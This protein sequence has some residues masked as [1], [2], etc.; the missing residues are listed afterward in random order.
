MKVVLIL[1]LILSLYSCDNNRKRAARIIDQNNP[2]GII[3]DT[4]EV[5]TPT[6]DQ[7]TN[8]QSA[9]A[10]DPKLTQA[11]NQMEFLQKNV[12]DSLADLSSSKKLLETNPSDKM[13]IDAASKDWNFFSSEANK[14]SQNYCQNIIKIDSQSQLQAG[15]LVN[16]QFVNQEKVNEICDLTQTYFQANMI[17]SEIAELTV[18]VIDDPA[19]VTTTTTTL[20]QTNDDTEITETDDVNEDEGSLPKIRYCSKEFLKAHSYTTT[21]SELFA[22]SIEDL[23]IQQA[24]ALNE[25]LSAAER[26][27]AKI[28]FEAKWKSSFGEK[29]VVDPEVPEGLF[30]DI[31]NAC[32]SLDRMVQEQEA[33]ILSAENKK[34]IKDSSSFQDIC[35]VERSEML[36]LNNAAQ[37]IANLKIEAEVTE[38]DPVVVVTE[39][40]KK[41]DKKEVVVEDPKK[42]KK[43]E[44]KKEEKEVV[45]QD[46]KKNKK[47]EVKKEEKEVVVQ[48]PKKDKKP[49]V[50]KEEKEVV[51]TEVK[52]DNTC[53]QPE[54]AWLAKMHRTAWTL[55]DNYKE[56]KSTYD[57]SKK[58]QDPKP[59]FKTFKEVYDS[60]IKG[61]AKDAGRICLT[62]EKYRQCEG[63]FPIMR[64]GSQRMYSAPS[65]EEVQKTC[66]LLKTHHM[67]IKTMVKN[68]NKRVKKLNREIKARNE[69]IKKKVSQ[70]DPCSDEIYDLVTEIDTKES[71]IKSNFDQVKNS[72]GGKL[73][74][75]ID[76]FERVVKE[77]SDSCEELSREMGGLNECKDPTNITVIIDLFDNYLGKKCNTSII[78]TK[79]REIKK[80]ANL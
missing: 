55:F 21:V 44:V 51:I 14:L 65:A 23:K 33:C 2:G 5:D 22:T 60:K 31:V 37:E 1:G 34:V 8:P 54:L 46:P 76:D 10:C 47:P 75:N 62:V 40:P 70:G 36:L 48:D 12:K 59:Y 68:I 20:V 28:N 43:P 79:V 25:E 38:E 17:K 7:P 27:N 72:S 4:P 30:G 57:S 77:L 53:T 45:V 78:E 66:T 50:K 61:V 6:T 63:Q 71:M 67:N 24:A 18:V 13:A 42:D 11:I 39:L 32:L 80:D 15:C 73:S 56:I 19:L 52:T 29:L 26:K 74:K 3:V 49:E 69:K 35:Q 16:V 9:N 64:Q 41:K 58:A